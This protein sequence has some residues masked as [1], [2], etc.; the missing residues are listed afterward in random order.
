MAAWYLPT[1]KIAS[2]RFSH[3]RRARH[4]P[5]FKPAPQR[6]TPPNEC[7]VSASTPALLAGFK[8]ARGRF[9]S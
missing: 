4:F 3:E 6:R 1:H 5:V 2:G 9:F 8:H 7:A